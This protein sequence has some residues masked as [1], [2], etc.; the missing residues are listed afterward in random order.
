M[1]TLTVDQGLAE[2]REVSQRLAELRKQRDELIRAH[3]GTLREI[4]EAAGLSFQQ[5]GNIRNRKEEK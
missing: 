2:L 5:V 3:P 1:T 4:A